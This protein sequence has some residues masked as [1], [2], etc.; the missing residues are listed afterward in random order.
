MCFLAVSAFVPKHSIEEP[1]LLV[2]AEKSAL[3]TDM[4]LAALAAAV[5]ALVILSNS[6]VSLGQMSGI[7][8]ITNSGAYAFIGAAAALVIA[9]LV[10]LFVQMV[11]HI[12]K[13]VNRTQELS[14]ANRIPL[15]EKRVEEI[16]KK[17]EED[18]KQIASLQQKKSELESEAAKLNKDIDELHK[19]IKATEE[20]AKQN[21]ELRLKT[22]NDGY[23]REL[24][25]LRHEI[26]LKGKQIQDLK[27]KLASALKDPKAASLQ[28]AASDLKS[29]SDTKQLLTKENENLQKSIENGNAKLKEVINEY[30]Q[31][32]NDLLKCDNENAKTK[33]EIEFHQ[34]ELVK[35]KNESGRFESHLLQLQNDIHKKERELENLVLKLIEHE[36]KVVDDEA[37]KE[38]N[39]QELQQ[40]QE[41]F[42]SAK[43]AAEKRL[44]NDEEQIALLQAHIEKLEEKVQENDKIKENME[45]LLQDNRALS[46]KIEQLENELVAVKNANAI[47]AEEEQYSLLNQPPKEKDQAVATHSKKA[48]NPIY[49]KPI[50]K[51]EVPSSS[52][53]QKPLALSLKKITSMFER[54]SKP[55]SPDDTAEN[56]T[57]ET[58]NELR[59]RN[60]SFKQL[61]IF[62]GHN[63]SKLNFEQFENDSEKKKAIV[64]VTQKNFEELKELAEK[65]KHQHTQVANLSIAQDVEGRES[66]AET[67]T[68]E[69]AKAENIAIF[70]E[71]RDQ[72]IQPLARIIDKEN[73]DLL[74]DSLFA[75]SLKTSSDGEIHANGL[76]VKT[77]VGSDDENSNIAGLFEPAK[78]SQS[79][80]R[81]E[82][83]PLADQDIIKEVFEIKDSASAE[84][85]HLC[86]ILKI[87]I[88]NKDYMLTDLNLSK[89]SPDAISAITEATER[90]VEDLITWTADLKSFMQLDDKD[91][92]EQVI[93]T[94][95]VTAEKLTAA[96]HT[97]A[98]QKSSNKKL[99]KL[100]HLFNS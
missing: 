1:Y 97:I 58:L 28:L 84:S 76:K 11:K 14:N 82:H 33:R 17:N 27:A 66:I 57:Q 93:E 40:R 64:E 60:E 43:I 13:L 44:K 49:Q 83:E 67:F 56:F 46:S 72:L 91:E 16:S 38:K 37:I 41:E 59:R 34:S 50:G 78:S 6:G 65:I 20:M 74:L 32:Y 77:D 92:T 54:N 8:V 4:A 19:E 79:S 25:K 18:Q 3:I 24:Q 94:F 29:I 39:K 71:L 80:P 15:L 98:E 95:K 26:D 81:S 86:D 52:S 100:E 73:K 70:A 85:V 9:D 5:A 55:T 45:T 63:I 75:S 88:H 23:E 10:K 62:G 96:L 68:R 89:L 87:K 2:C 51:P 35:I 42:Q 22:V 21:S 69:K 30:T 53:I 90:T 48:S 47:I 31:K 99:P 36:K 7:G 12:N 61:E